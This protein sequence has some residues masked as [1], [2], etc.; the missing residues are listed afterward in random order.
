M[1]IAEAGRRAGYAA[2]QSSH[3]AY[4]RLKL[5]IPDKLKAL[6]CPVD[7]VLM[8]VISK[9][10]AEE[11]K[12]G[13]HKGKLVQAVNVVDHDTQLRAADM[14]LDLYNAYP[15]NGRHEDESH[16]QPG[17]PSFTLVIADPERAAAIRERLAHIRSSHTPASLGTPLD[18]DEGRAG[19][20]EP[21]QTPP[22]L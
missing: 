12:M 1:S 21:L 16:A 6:G 15:R 7:K 10:E 17:G 14:L 8:K 5:L 9:L 4:E 11:T 20:R 2:P 19:P 22:K 18:E 13:W 3:R